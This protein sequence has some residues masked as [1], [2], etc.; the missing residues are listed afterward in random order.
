MEK[1]E[2]APFQIIGITVRTTNQNN[3]GAE[4]IGELFNKFLSENLMTKIPNRVENDIYSVYTDYESDH[5]GHY[6]TLLGCK[7]SSLDNTPPGMVGKSICGGTYTTFVAKGDLS[8]G[9]VAKEW[10]KIWDSGIK[11]AYSADYEIYGEKA[12]N[13]KDAEVPIYIAI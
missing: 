3:Q 9:V 5:T 4:D 1:V 8:K 2:V 12:Q 10:M 7:V 13:P 6:T 11:R